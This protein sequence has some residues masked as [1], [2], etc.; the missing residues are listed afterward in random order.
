MG[1]A[2]NTAQGQEQDSHL[3]TNTGS[4]EYNYFLAHVKLN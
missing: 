1:F 2:K 4:G 3:D